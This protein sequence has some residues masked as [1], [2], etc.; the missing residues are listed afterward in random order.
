M[1]IRRDAEPTEAKDRGIHELREKYYVRPPN[2]T[3]GYTLATTSQT[4]PAQVVVGLVLLRQG[5][6]FWGHDETEGSLN[7]GNFLILLEFLGAHNKEIND[8]ILKNAPKTCKLTSPDIQKDIVKAC[9]TETINVII[10]DIGNSLFSILV[11]ESCDVSMKEQIA[12]TLSLK[13]AIDMMFSKYNLSIAN[14][15]LALIA[16]TK[17]NLS[18]SNF[19]RI[20][21]DVVNVVGSFCKYSDLLKEKHLDFIV[22]TL[23]RGEISSGRELNQETTLQRAGDIRWGSHY[24]SLISLIS[25]FSA[26]NNVLE[27]ISEDNSSS[28][29]QKTETFNLLE[30][31]LSIDFAFNLH[32]MKHVLRIS[33][34]LS[35]TLQ[36]KDQDIVNAM[37]LVQVCKHRLQNMRED[38]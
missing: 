38:G 20:V 18:I 16:V 23:E 5:N 6:S 17:K 1:P 2:H 26:V 13:A 24:N 37:D 31:I 22:E 4:P 29:D 33:S 27:M 11:D 8:V 25:M 30:S 36:K 9:T 15:Q 10:K 12:T 21:G 28:L 19:L 3:V 35:T 7:P 32:L 34:E 14:L